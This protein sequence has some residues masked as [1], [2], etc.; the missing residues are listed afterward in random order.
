MHTLGAARAIARQEYPGVTPIFEEQLQLFS[1]D[2]MPNIKP[3]ERPKKKIGGSQKSAE[4]LPFDPPP[5][6]SEG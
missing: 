4:R 2:G 6:P 1:L 3:P 5:P